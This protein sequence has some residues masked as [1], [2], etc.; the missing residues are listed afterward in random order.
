[1]TEIRSVVNF[2]LGSAYKN[3]HVNQCSNK[4]ALNCFRLLSLEG[5]FTVIEDS[6]PINTENLSHRLKVRKVRIN[7]RFILHVC[8]I[9]FNLHSNTYTVS[10]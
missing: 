7:L 2:N 1:M 4:W 9:F 3:I 6:Q 5:G 8:K 10:E